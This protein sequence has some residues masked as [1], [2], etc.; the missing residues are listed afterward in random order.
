MSSPDA[1]P[2]YADDIEVDITSYVRWP[3]RSARLSPSRKGS[4]PF[5]PSSLDVA[6]ARPGSDGGAVRPAPAHLLSAGVHGGPVR[7]QGT[8]RGEHGQRVG[9]LR[10]VN[11]PYRDWELADVLE[12]AEPGERDE[13]ARL[14]DEQ[15]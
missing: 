4:L 2:E 14:I 5:R 7:Y 6:Q 8:Y 3:E 15:R 9:L 13:V 11:G 1:D 12:A 10:T